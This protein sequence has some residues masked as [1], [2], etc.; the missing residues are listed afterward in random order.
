M[1]YCCYP[2]R[3]LQAFEFAT[4]SL[5]SVWKLYVVFAIRRISEGKRIAV[6][7]CESLEEKNGINDDN[8]I[9]DENELVIKIWCAQLGDGVRRQTKKLKVK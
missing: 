7:Y 9:G 8:E 5:A 2:W 1:D 6:K 4:G 3:F